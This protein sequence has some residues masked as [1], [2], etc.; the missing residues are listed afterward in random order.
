MA[1]W[2]FGGM[3]FSDMIKTKVCNCAF[4]ADKTV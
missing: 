4:F 3:G 2:D 1:A